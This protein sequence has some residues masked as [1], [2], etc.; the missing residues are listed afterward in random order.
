[1]YLL[2]CGKEFSIQFGNDELMGSQDHVSEMALATLTSERLAKKDGHVLA[3]GLGMGFTLDAVLASW[4]S[5]AFVTVAEL[6][7]QII[8]WAKGPLAHL[9]KENLMD[10]RLSLH[11]RDVHNIIAETS[12]HFDAILLDVDNGP[13]GFITP[14]N[15]RLY[16][17][18]GIAAAY[19]ALRPGG[20]LSVWSSYTDDC[21]AGRLEAS[22][23][24]VDEIILPAYIGST[25]R[26]HNIW[27]AAKPDKPAH[28]SNMQ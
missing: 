4:A 19:A 28:L 8:V 2:K 16:S 23:F 1:M 25:E 13:D 14:L 12:E 6:V 17:H 24:K 21:F 5:D 10:P 27:F 22:G 3:G 11:L 18:A 7:P 20:L 9:F 15:D 26:W